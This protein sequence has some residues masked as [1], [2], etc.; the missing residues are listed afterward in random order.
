MILGIVL[1]AGANAGSFLAAHGLVRRI[2]TQSDSVN[3]LL[4]LVVRLLL[5]SV[6]VL[7][8]GLTYSLTAAGVACPWILAGAILLATGE[9]RRLKFSMPEVSRITYALSALV[10][11]RLLAQVWFFAPHL[12]DTLNYYLPKVAEWTVAGGFVRELGI[13]PHVTLP[14]GFELVETWWVV[15]LHHDVLIEMAGVEFLALA[16]CATYVLAGRLGLTV[17]GAFLAAALYVMTPGVHLAATSCLN[18]LPAAALVVSTAALI[19]SRLPVPHLL[20]LAGLG[21]G[22]KPTYAYALPGLALLWWLCRKEEAAV[23]GRAPK[24]C[25]ALLGGAAFVGAFW[26]VRNYLW[27]RNPIYPIG[28]P[29]PTFPPPQFGPR[30]SS[31]VGNAGDLINVRIYDSAHAQGA[32]VDG[33]A[34]WGAVGFACGLVALLLGMRE[35]L[36]LRRLGAAFV[37]SLATVLLLSIHDP[38]CMKYVFFFPSVLC[39]ATA[40]LAERSVGVLRVAL[41]ALLLEVGATML[42]Y[43]LPLKD[44]STLARQSWH[45]RNAGSLQGLSVPAKEVGYLGGYSGSPY[46]LYQ[47]NFSSRVKYLRLASAADLPRSVEAASVEV[48]FAVPDDWRPVDGE[49]VVTCLREGRLKVV[50]NC[51]FKLVR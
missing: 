38:W 35:D 19:L 29:N 20:S 48:F 49:A 44:F 21:I 7:V 9:H 13:H 25:L 30:W 34:G 3:V 15:F 32:M 47:P 8:A 31:F 27:F 36:R 24:T 12:G 37:L 45:E 17:R 18:D 26:Y 39:V 11:L 43:D 6:S 51:W 40:R 10:V 28:E 16:F 4:L 46:L 22:I 14:A 23:C 5:I 2:G 1:M 42:P 33:I 41:A 50:G